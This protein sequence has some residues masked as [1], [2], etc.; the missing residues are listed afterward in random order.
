[1]KIVKTIKI[2]LFTLIIISCGKDS[3]GG[4]DVISQSQ[5]NNSSENE[6]PRE[7]E[8]NHPFLIVTK[9]MYNELGKKQILNHGNQ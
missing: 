2:L 6:I 7:K 1:M 3:S 5:I 4:R 8:T 9:D